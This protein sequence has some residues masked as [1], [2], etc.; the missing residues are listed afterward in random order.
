MPT[1]IKF[2]LIERPYYDKHGNTLKRALSTTGYGLAEIYGGGKLYPDMSKITVLEWHEKGYDL[3]V[4]VEGDQAEVDKLLQD[5]AVFLQAS[6]K[7]VK[8]IPD[9]F[10]VK[11]FINADKVSELSAIGIDP[12]VI[13]GV[14]K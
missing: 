1:W 10:K 9:G 3:A 6:P 14:T 7:E 5:K 2:K 4:L 12:K 11:T 13:S 8:I